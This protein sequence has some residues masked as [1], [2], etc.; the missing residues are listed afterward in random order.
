MTVIS[1]W[2][3]RECADCTKI[4]DADL[5]TCPTCE[6]S[7]AG[8]GSFDVW[9]ARRHRVTDPPTSKA[10][11]EK[12]EPKVGTQQAKLLDAYRQLGKMTDRAAGIAAGIGADNG[13][14]RA[15]E[16]LQKGLLVKAGENVDPETGMT[17]RLLD[18]PA[19]KNGT[20]F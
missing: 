8:Q 13:H 4:A 2:A 3:V 14:K 16:L 10:A 15:P 9:R 12:I 18:A 19:G 17:V 7:L 5:D 1:R 20:L 6:A 11:A